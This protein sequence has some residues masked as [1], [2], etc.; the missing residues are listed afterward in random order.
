MHEAATELHDALCP[1]AVVALTMY[2][3][4]SAIG[5]HDSKE[6]LVPQIRALLSMEGAQ[7]AEREREIRTGISIVY[8]RCISLKAV[9]SSTCHY[10]SS[11]SSSAVTGGILSLHS[12]VVNLPTLQ[13]V[14]LAGG[15]VASAGGVMLR[16]AVLCKHSVGHSPRNSG[17]GHCGHV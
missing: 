8:G 16:T 4:A 1:S 17:P 11:G 9:Q 10:H 3:V 13:L 7:G 12:N 15:C 14:Q 6:E 2:P 5:V